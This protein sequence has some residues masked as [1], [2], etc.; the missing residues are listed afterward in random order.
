M[1]ELEWLGT[2][3]FESVEFEGM[4]T[5]VLSSPIRKGNQ[6][7]TKVQDRSRNQVS[8]ISDHSLWLLVLKLR[9]EVLDD[10]IRENPS[11]P[12]AL[13]DAYSIHSEEDL[14]LKELLL[15]MTGTEKCQNSEMMIFAR[16]ATLVNVRPT[17]KAFWKG[18]PKKLSHD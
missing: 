15:E 13:F 4:L 16:P 11:A 9:L 14:L 5:S 6:K 12:G 17:Q 7:K 10:V 18:S 3:L 1:S 2:R 8:I